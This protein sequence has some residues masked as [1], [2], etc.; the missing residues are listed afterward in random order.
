MRQY[1]I[2]LTKQTYPQFFTN[3]LYLFTLASVGKRIR[4][5]IHE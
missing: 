2:Y 3:L 4:F 5:Y 1:I